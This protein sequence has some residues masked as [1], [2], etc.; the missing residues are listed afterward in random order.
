MTAKLIIFNV[1][2]YY[3]TIYVFPKDR[4]AF[5]AENNTLSNNGRKQNTLSKPAQMQHL[6]YKTQQAVE[7]IGENKQ[8]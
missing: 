2:P 4:K 5:E 7:K 8:Q 1:I 3:L 6:D